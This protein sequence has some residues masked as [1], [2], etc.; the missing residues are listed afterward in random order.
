MTLWEWVIGSPPSISQTASAAARAQKISK[1]IAPSSDLTR[2]F[3]RVHWLS[4]RAGGLH[5]LP[6]RPRGVPERRTVARATHPR[7]AAWGW[8]AWSAAAGSRLS[9]RAMLALGQDLK[10]GQPGD[11]AGLRDRVGDDR[12]PDQE[13]LRRDA[14]HGRAWAACLLRR[15][16]AV[17]LGAK[18]SPRSSGRTLRA[19][20]LP[21]C[22]QW[23]RCR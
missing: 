23:Q 17:R 10:P 3:W 13:H 7:P 19:S 18:I 21:S 6:N 1:C 14:R 16:S 9:C 12:A 22:S 2:H 20:Q 8:R 15:L 4:V 5:H 11:A